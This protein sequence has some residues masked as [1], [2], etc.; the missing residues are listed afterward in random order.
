MS[1]DRARFSYD[2]TRQYRSVVAQQGRVT[3]E[4]DLNEARAIATEN[5]RAETL[6]IVGPCGTPDD[7]G[8][9]VTGA[10]LPG[11]TVGAGT[12]YVGGLRVALPQSV[13]Y[14]NQSE[15]L[16]HDGD[17]LWV[18]PKTI[19]GKSPEF[20]YL[21]LREQEVSAVEDAPLREVAL[22]GPDTAQRT[23][24]IQRIVRLA[25]NAR[26]CES[27]LVI[28]E[29]TWSGLGV[30]FD[31]K[32]MM[33]TSPARLQVKF[34]QQPAP[35][36]P[37]DP[38]VQG[39]YLGADNQ[40]IRVQITAVDDKTKTGR[41]VWGYNDASFLSRIKVVDP[42]TIELTA[43]PI[44]SYHTPGVNRAMEILRSAVN[45]LDDNYIAAH[46]GF[47]TTPSQAY[48]P[49]TRRLALPPPFLPGAYVGNTEPSFLRLWEAEVHFTSGQP[50]DLTG[51]GLQVVID[52]GGASGALTVGQ[53][54]TFAVRPSTPVNIYPQR[55]LDSGKPPEGPRL[56]VCPLATI[57]WIGRKFT[58]LADC[59]EKF[60][61]LVDLTKRRSGCCSIVIKPEDVAGGAGLAKLID[62]LRGTPA[63]ISLQPGQYDLLEPIII[64]RDHKGL[65]LEGCQDGAVLAAKP[66]SEDKFGD[67]LIILA[68]ANDCTLR[69]LRLQ[70]PLAMSQARENALVSIGVRVIHCADLRIEDCLFRF[71]LAPQT[72]VEAIAIWVNDECWNMR[73]ERN[74]FLHDDQYVRDRPLDRLLIGLA[75]TEAIP[76]QAAQ[77]RRESQFVPVLLENVSIAGNEFAGLTLAVFVRAEFGRLRCEN[78]FAHGC[79]GGFYFANTTQQLIRQSLLDAFQNR[80]RTPANAALFAGL[81]HA[82]QAPL[83]S[84]LHDFAARN[85]LPAGP[86][87]RN[88]I[89]VGRAADAATS[90]TI[91][92]DATRINAQ[93][94]A[95]LGV[96]AAPGTTA[97]I[98]AAKPTDSTSATENASQPGP[99]LDISAEE[100]RQITHSLMV[101]F[102][103]DVPLVR[104]TPALR[105]SGNDVQI[106]PQT[107]SP[108]NILA[109]SRVC[110]WV[111]LDNQLG[112]SVMLTANDLRG[113][114][115]QPIAIVVY[116]KIAVVTGN[117]VLNAMGG[118]GIRSLLVL[119]DEKNGLMDVSG[120]AFYGGY[121]INPPPPGAGSGAPQPGTENGDWWA[122]NSRKFS[123]L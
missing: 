11:F 102:P 31:P 82:A 40:L 3:L 32:T 30:E 59:R 95:A 85:P 107:T 88:T 43:A 81:L 17:P 121:V 69:R 108:Q 60:D 20:I 91:R 54:W 87:V 105:F 103:A 120:N 116:S 86:P 13:S 75:A 118:D 101:R 93:L 100:I 22:G 79:D 113:S 55:Y 26:E 123:G 14:D 70:L 50:A 64:S 76:G 84:A 97:D 6:D 92:A 62:T 71:V 46:S 117:L 56:W 16:D 104:H 39:G 65:T 98:A 83:L 94:L 119:V 49:E 41:F 5:A 99:S 2:P 10:A 42:Q 29:Q 35:P 89:D 9:A 45:L 34:V 21:M 4:A 51:T 78:N 80:A 72:S 28:A 25:V 19:D 106:M 122:L 90:K 8:Y 44:D 15:W 36:T 61:D 67:G 38:Q 24:L 111:M 114:G 68:N 109:T 58:L 47:V 12:M 63:T 112:G 18:D 48:V 23:R 53:F 27:A 52:L 57:G 110:L 77:G 74:R 1:S 73:V 7:H 37:C 96:A 66:G 33:L 115:L